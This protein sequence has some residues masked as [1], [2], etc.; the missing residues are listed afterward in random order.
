M[1]T[2]KT[3]SKSYII[4]KNGELEIPQKLAKELKGQM[5]GPS[6]FKNSYLRAGIWVVDVGEYEIDEN[7]IINIVV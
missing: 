6:R 5:E 3:H 1:N 2:K 7:N 4:L